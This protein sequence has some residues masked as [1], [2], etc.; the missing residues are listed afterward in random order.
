MTH[1]VPRPSR[2]ITAWTMRARQWHGR[3]RAA[4]ARAPRRARTPAAVALKVDGPRAGRRADRHLPRPPRPRHD[5]DLRRH[6][7]RGA[8][9]AVA[10]R[11]AAA[12]PVRPR[13][14][15]RRATATRPRSSTP[16][17]PARCATR[18]SPPTPCSPSGASRS[19][20][21][22]GARVGVDRSVALDVRLPAHRLMPVALVAPERHLTVAPVCG[23]RTLAEGRP[24][25]GIACA[26]QDVAHVYPLPDDPERCLEDFLE[27]AA[28]HAR[29]T[30]RAAS[31]SRRRRSSAS[32]SST[33][34][35]CRRP[36][37][38]R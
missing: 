11:R 17:R 1:G 8:G 18:S 7:G 14:R 22:A 12:R 30:G 29:A 20:E 15:R 37:D 32:S 25:L 27:R 34:R 9:A 28:D 19:S 35:T 36:A 10:R 5:P 23:A 24:P 13:P 6:G 3:R 16:S 21:L 26:Q 4:A 33:A 38:G 31:S 2:R